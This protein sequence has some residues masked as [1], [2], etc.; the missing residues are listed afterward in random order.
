MRKTLLAYLG[1]FATL[2]LVVGVTYAA[3]TDKAS[4]LGSTFSTGS[5][6]IKLLADVTKSADAGN[7]VEDLEGPRFASISPN[8]SQNY[9]VK[10]YNNAAASVLLS[11]AVNYETA[12]D[13]KE[14]RQLIYVEPFEWNDN[15]NGL[16]DEGELG[17]SY[18]RKS[19]VKWKTER[20]SLGQIPSGQ[21]RGLVL[22]FSTDSL[23]DFKQG[24]SAV[25]DFVF[26][27]TG[28]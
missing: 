15:G 26:T 10:I 1:V 24:A 3:F 9:L 4:V 11:S 6:D 23:S 27:S 12:T 22:K 5:A 18:G 2:F 21:V 19:F 25:F 17:I 14:L 8:W 16:L 28:L 20:I 13:P 7:L